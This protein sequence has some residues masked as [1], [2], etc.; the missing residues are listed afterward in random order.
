MRT[1]IKVC[2]AMTRKPIAVTED[3][4]VKECVK[5]MKANSVGSLIVNDK[6]DSKKL[7]GMITYK[8]LVHKVILEDLDAKKTKAKQIMKTDED[9]ITIEPH[10]DIF[11]A[12]SKMRDLDKR[13]M[14]VVTKEGKLVGL[15]TLKDILKIEPQLFD[16]MVEKIEL[17][18]EQYKPVFSKKTSDGICDLCGSKSNSLEDINGQL[19]CNKCMNI[20]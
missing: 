8:S 3:T 2:D 15:L 9:Y 14:P 16:L 10:V 18:E 12:I 13:Q 20:D 7:K 11:D 6:K 4:S 1:G 19:I 5:I 17:K